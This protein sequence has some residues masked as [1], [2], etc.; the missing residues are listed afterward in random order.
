[1]RELRTRNNK[2]NLLAKIELSRIFISLQNVSFPA[3]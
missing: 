3:T 2:N 1:M